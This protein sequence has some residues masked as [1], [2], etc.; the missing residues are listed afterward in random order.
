MTKAAIAAKSDPDERQIKMPPPAQHQ[1][2][3]RSC[4]PRT[5]A[6]PLVHREQIDCGKEMV[7]KKPFYGASHFGPD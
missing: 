6:S 1:S 3:V 5:P 7:Q 2:I 4:A